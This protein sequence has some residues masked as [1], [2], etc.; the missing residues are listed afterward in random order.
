[1]ESDKDFLEIEQPK[2]QEDEERY[3]D[4]TLQLKEDLMEEEQRELYIRSLRLKHMA[5]LFKE[6]EEWKKSLFKL[7]KFKVLKM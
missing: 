2:I 3:I 7:K 4:E 5:S 1:M 6:R